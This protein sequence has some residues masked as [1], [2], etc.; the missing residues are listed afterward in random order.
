MLVK[1][2]LVSRDTL[3]EELQKIS[4]GIG[5]AI[6]LSDF[7]SNMD[8]MRM[9]DSIMQENLGADGEVSG[10]G[11]PHNGLEQ[12]ALQIYERDNLSHISSKAV[13]V[14]IFHSLGAQLSYLWKLFLQFHRFAF[15][16]D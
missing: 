6:D 11:K 12:M 14:N 4:K 10:Q 5:H 8:D 16:P 3:L 9:F 2:L 13:V 7:I 1:A 15:P